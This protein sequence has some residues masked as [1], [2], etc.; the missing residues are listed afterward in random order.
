MT[1]Q[2]TP[3]C[4][5]ALVVGNPRHLLPGLVDV[6]AQRFILKKLRHLE[7]RIARHVLSIVTARIQ[8]ATGEDNDALATRALRSH[9][10]HGVLDAPGV[11]SYVLRALDLRALVS[12]EKSRGELLTL[13]EIQE[14]QYGPG[15]YMMFARAYRVAIPEIDTPLRIQLRQ[16]TELVGN[17]L[18][19]RLIP[20][21]TSTDVFWTVITDLEVVEALGRPTDKQLAQ[22]LLSNEKLGSLYLEALPGFRE[23][24]G[25]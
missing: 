5:A 16:H 9:E 15:G 1:L 11:M 14:F 7:G 13:R 19:Q 18:D 24:H 20:G 21:P 25:G 4:M 23:R 17:M 3:D 8:F 12:Y 22:L 10:R 2:G 6:T